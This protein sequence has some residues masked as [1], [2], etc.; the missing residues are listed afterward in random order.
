MGKYRQNCGNL[1]QTIANYAKQSDRIKNLL[2][3]RKLI[4]KK[5]G[6]AKI[7]HFISN[8]QIEIA[9]KREFLGPFTGSLTKQVL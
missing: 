6:K 5:E 4:F 3:K 9:R 7:D 8:R 2:E 1:Q